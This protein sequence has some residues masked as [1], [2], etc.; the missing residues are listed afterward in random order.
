MVQTI[1]MSIAFT[2][3]KT[4]PPM[5][6]D[7]CCS[8][9]VLLHSIGCFFYLLMKKCSDLAKEL[10]SKGSMRHVKN[11]KCAHM[12]LWRYLATTR[13]ELASMIV[14]RCLVIAR[15]LCTCCVFF[16][17]KS[18]SDLTTV[19]IARRN[20]ASSHVAWATLLQRNH[21][22]LTCERSITFLRKAS[23]ARA[24]L[25]GQRQYG[26][27]PYTSNTVPLYRHGRF[28]PDTSNIVQP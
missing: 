2:L 24:T 5:T 13:C 14:A 26:L 11:E 17:I 9:S 4:K 12:A 3:I 18:M 28:A 15:S 6:F 8:I 25:C 19:L 20:I 1:D 16:L 22:E 10:F 21:R 23:R 7:T 27:A